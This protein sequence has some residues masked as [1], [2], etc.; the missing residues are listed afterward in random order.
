M[1]NKAMAIGVRTRIIYWTLFRL[2]RTRARRDRSLPVRFSTQK[3]RLKSAS[4]CFSRELEGA[5][6]NQRMPRIFAT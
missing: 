6:R 3:A 4:T 2:W 5:G 1:K